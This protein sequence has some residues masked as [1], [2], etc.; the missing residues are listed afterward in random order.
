MSTPLEK[1]LAHLDALK[2]E[3][4]AALALSELKAEEAK[5]IKARLEG[6]KTAIEMLGG[7]V[8]AENAEASEPK[9]PG[10]RRSRRRIRE[11][12]SREL[13]FSGQAMT[14]RQI[15]KA[16]DYNLERTETALQRM[17]EARQ[18]CRNG[19]GRWAIGIT[20]MAQLDERPTDAGNGRS[21]RH[22]APDA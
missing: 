3:R 20:T 11:L 18:V 13:S 10:R 9:E 22:P 5:L 1:A 4:E 16:I 21:P 8:P 14:A 7:K 19:T 12:I 17:E 2:A 6:F 15:A